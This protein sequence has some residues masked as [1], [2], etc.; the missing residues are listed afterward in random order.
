MGQK[1]RRRR[2]GL[3]LTI[4][5][6]VW[7]AVLILSVLIFF[8]NKDQSG[9]WAAI[10][11]VLTAVGGVLAG[12]VERFTARAAGKR[13]RSTRRNRESGWLGNVAEQL[14]EAVREQWETEAG[15][16]RLDDPWPLNVSWL[17]EEE[18]TDPTYALPRPR[19]RGTSIERLEVPL[20]GDLTRVADFFESLPS[21]RLVILG[22]LGSGKSVL[23]LTLLLDLLERWEPG[24]PV[25]V[26][27]P[28]NTWN[29][30]TATFPEW[31]VKQL[32]EGYQLVSPLQRDARE[33]ARGLLRDNMILP[34]LDGLDELAEP[35][36]PRAII[37][38]NDWL[39]RDRPVIV[40]SRLNEYYTTVTRGDVVTGG[41]AV[42][43]QPLTGDM[44]EEY[45]RAATAGP[46]I[47]RWTP[48]FDEM[49][50]NPNGPVATTLRSPLM[51]A[52]ARTI[53][54]DQPGDA[55]VLLSSRFDSVE[56]VEEHLLSELIRATY[57]DE[58]RDPPAEDVQDWLTFL[59]R[60]LSGRGRLGIAWWQLE[61]AAPPVAVHALAAAGGACVVGFIF[62]PIAALV[63][64]AVVL[65]LGGNP[66]LERWS[67]EGLLRKPVAAL[68]RSDSGAPR[69]GFLAAL[70]GIDE[71]ASLEHRLGLAVGRLV[72]LAAGLTQGFLSYQTGGLYVA[73]AEGV[74]LGLAVGLADGYFTITTRAVPSE[75]KF[76]SRRGVAAF[77]RHVAIGFTIGAGIGVTAWAI[78]SSWFGVLV[79]VIVGLAFGL[80]DGLNMW[81]DVSTD[82]TRALS[83][84][85]TRRAERLA[86]LAR[87]LTLGTTLAVT[88]GIA[89]TFAYGLE[90]AVVPALIFGVGYALADHHMGIATSVWG[91]FVMAKVW[92]A[93][94]GRLPWRFMDF[95]DD[96]H[97]RG[98]LRRA[99]A[100]YQFRHV[101]FQEHLAR[102]NDQRLVEA[103]GVPGGPHAK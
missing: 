44:V 102:R 8:V 66:Q 14:A 68:F 22:P 56:R 27:F 74:G 45:L 70:M 47:R 82:V 60:E 99:G 95:L 31:L 75:V 90:A 16:R 11:G 93:L 98:L 51:V 86:A 63:F 6:L 57:P 20:E 10:L 78:S 28:L 36:R 80:I 81:L 67:V 103:T 84:R 1:V 97:R 50:A 35:A 23:A 18:L 55:A 19:G 88:T 26:L 100:V 41:A 61:T 30:D 89:Y 34:V 4:F 83:P 3:F 87:S 76:A 42:M 13:G 58:R 2:S 40:T 69:G 39:G 54:S 29:P 92:L 21:R 37:D 65:V 101:R 49:R 59:A 96:T 25:P 52:L 77:L 62:G 91:R 7:G 53:Y 64:A 9:T 24:Q 43:L 73:V 33:I 32:A 15:L 38:I 94:R 17:K 71:R 72:A 85:S 46:R 79:G 12:Q 48:V 5:V